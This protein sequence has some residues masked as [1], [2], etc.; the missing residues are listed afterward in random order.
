MYTLIYSNG[1]KGTNKDVTKNVGYNVLDLFSKCFVS[2]L[3]NFSS[4]K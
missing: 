2:I 4:T 1:F 3:S